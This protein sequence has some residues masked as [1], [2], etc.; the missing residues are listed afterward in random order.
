MFIRIEVPLDFLTNKPVKILL[1]VSDPFC[2]L[3]CYQQL[4]NNQT[5]DCGKYQSLRRCVRNN[6]INQPRDTIVYPTSCGPPSRLI[7]SCQSSSPRLVCLIGKS[8]LR[9]SHTSLPRGAILS[10]DASILPISLDSSIIF[11]RNRTGAPSSSS[12]NC[13]SSGDTIALTVPKAK[14]GRRCRH[15]WFNVDAGVRSNV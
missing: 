8:D 3:I 4:F 9:P 14:S 6:S 13:V 15:I 7:T 2:F 11:I 5:Y 1:P 10:A 12:S